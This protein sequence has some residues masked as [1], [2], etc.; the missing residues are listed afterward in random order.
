MSEFEQ[1]IRAAF[2]RAKWKCIG[3]YFALSEDIETP[4][5]VGIHTTRAWG[6][7]TFQFGTESTSIYA[8]TI[9]ELPAAVSA[10]AQREI[11]KWQAIADTYGAK[12]E[13]GKR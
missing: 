2:P 11:A 10:R 13:E 4:T 9:E 12:T 5:G 6:E 3:A 7:T 1:K 8:D